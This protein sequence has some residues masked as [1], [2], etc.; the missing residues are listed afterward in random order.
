MSDVVKY[1]G[2]FSV[3]EL[4]EIVVDNKKRKQLLSDLEIEREMDI[5]SFVDFLLSETY[6]LLLEEKRSQALIL[7]KRIKPLI[8]LS[9]RENYVRFYLNLANSFMINNEYEGARKA[10]E[11]AKNMAYKINNP[12]LIVKSLNLLFAI[13]RTLEKDKALEY[14]IKSKQIAEKNNMV[15]NLVYTEVNIGLMHM[16]NKKINDAADSC[17]KV[18]EIVKDN[19]YSSTKLHMAS[20]FFLHLF[21]ENQG[22]I[23]APKYKSMVVD[24]VNLVLRTLSKVKNPNEIAKRLSILTM[25]SKIS[26]EQVE[27]ILPLL[28]DFVKQHKTTKKSILYAAIANGLGDYK[29]YSKALSI[30]PEALKNTK[31]L[32]DDEQQRIRKNYA[33][34]LANAINIT[35][36]YD[37]ASSSSDIV[38]LKNLKIKTDSDSLLGKPGVYKYRSAIT[39]SDAIFGLKRND[40]KKKIIE[41]LKDVIH[42][43]PAISSITHEK[44]NEEIIKNIEILLINAITYE[45]EM[46]SLLLSGSTV[47]EK[48]LNKKKRIFDGYQIIGHIV[49]DSVVRQKHFEEFDILLIYE[50]IKSPQKFKKVE[51]VSVSENVQKNYL[52]IIEK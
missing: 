26:D 40:I 8:P 35:M 9:S 37:L 27:R 1:I 42:I 23:V 52:T 46:C 7:L 33:Y 15:E 4:K 25:M 43:T 24:G 16:F 34:L 13:Y 11:K 30:F 45:N 17:K 32:T 49:P 31:K 47:N 48:S 10:A 21:S 2:A 5:S 18:I 29:G 51:I 14:L 12:E 41:N 20:D 3:D 38:K 22:L 28:L 50:L 19:A 39:D 44:K 36:V 6:E